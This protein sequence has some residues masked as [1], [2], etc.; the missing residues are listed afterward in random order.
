MTKTQRSH[1]WV[2]L[3]FV[4]L[5]CISIFLTYQAFTRFGGGEPATRYRHVT[6]TDA[7]MEC[8]Q[9]LKSTYGRDLRGYGEDPLSTR[10]DHRLGLYRVYFNA[11]VIDLETHLPKDVFV[12]CDM[13]ERGEIGHFFTGEEGEDGEIEIEDEGSNPFGYDY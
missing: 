1:L 7:F 6:M 4:A 11:V 5:V 9:R 13:N 3:T 2:I 10:Y 12:S 8:K